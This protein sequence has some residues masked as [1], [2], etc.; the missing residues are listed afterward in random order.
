MITSHLAQVQS[1]WSSGEWLER[2]SMRSLKR[3][4]LFLILLSLLLLLFICNISLECD[5]REHQTD[6]ALRAG[7]QNTRH[8]EV[9]SGIVTLS[10]WLGSCTQGAMLQMWC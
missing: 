8:E 4:T 1:S 10:L 9:L 3:A 7:D 5:P 6:G 2:C